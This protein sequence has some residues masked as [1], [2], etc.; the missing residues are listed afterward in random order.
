M[1][2]SVINAVIGHKKAVIAAAAL[3]GLMLYA[4]PY[5]MLASA[6]H[7]DINISQDIE[8]P[9]LPYCQNVEPPE[10]IDIDNEQASL[11]VQIT[12]SFVSA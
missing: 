9:C 10:D 6:D 4:F 12:F 8:I 5:N 1:F 3:T 11:H 2:E 7:R